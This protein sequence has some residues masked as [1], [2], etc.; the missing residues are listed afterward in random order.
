MEWQRENRW[1]L[2]PPATWKS[3]LPRGGTGQLAQSPPHLFEPLSGIAG[4]TLGPEN[5][6]G[7]TTGPAFSHK[8]HLR[9]KRVT[10]H[11]ITRILVPH[12]SPELGT[13]GELPALRGIVADRGCGVAQTA[14]VAPARRGMISSR[15]KSC[16]A[17]GGGVPVS[18]GSLPVMRGSFPHPAG[19][20]PVVCKTIPSSAGSI[21]PVAGMIPHSGGFIPAACKSLFR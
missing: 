17:T 20:I 2:A 6:K 8:T 12:Q 19:M 10:H 13:W 14:G 3:S 18:A 1:W 4:S 5:T 21:P 16:P 7:R 9:T 15:S 11:E